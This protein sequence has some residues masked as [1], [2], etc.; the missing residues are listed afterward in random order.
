MK[1]QGFITYVRFLSLSLFLPVIAVPTIVMA[2][3]SA[4]DAKVYVVSPKDGDTVSS[5]VTVIFGLSGMG[6]APAGVD[7]KD[8]GHHHLL[9]DGEKL[10]DMKKPM[11]QD[12][13]HFG[14]GQTEATLDLKPGTHT[15]QLILG[16]KA[17]QPHNPPLVSE[18]VTITVK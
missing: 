11:G 17:H 15:L 9:V 2:T 14:G 16:D 5:P 3:P 7:K 6:V 10:P 13:K 18:K 8:T 4:Q 12:V 1:S